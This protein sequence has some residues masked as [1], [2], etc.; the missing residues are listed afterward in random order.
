MIGNSKKY[1]AST[2]GIVFVVAAIVFLL[3][4]LSWV[5][6]PFY[7]PYH[8][9][10]YSRAKACFINLRV[11]HGALEMYE[12]DHGTMERL[13]LKVLYDGKYL[14]SEIRCPEAGTGCFHGRSITS[15]KIADGTAVSC[16]VHGNAAE[17]EKMIN[18]LKK[19]MDFENSVIGR[20]GAA[21][22]HLFMI[23]PKI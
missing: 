17:A 16:E 3:Y 5:L 15:E 1:G 4:L 20:C 11:I 13:D 9:M 12:M 21:I 22:R 2:V 14:K 8:G 23:A 19:L 7:K 18:E 6:N 10:D